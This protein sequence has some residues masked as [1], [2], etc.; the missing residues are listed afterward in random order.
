[1]TR[2]T[3]AHRI[4]IL[5]GMSVLLA[6]GGCGK[7]ECC[8]CDKLVPR[9]AIPI[10]DEAQ[11]LGKTEADYPE[12]SNPIWKYMDGDT[13]D[14][15]GKHK[16]LELTP[17]EEKGRN[18]WL[19]W[20]GG[21][22]AFWDWFADHSLGLCDLLKV[23]DSRDRG[24]RFEKYGLMSE[25]G[26]RQNLT[27]DENGLYLDVRTDP[28]E[29]SKESVYGLPSGI[30]GLRLFKNPNF[31]EN[32]K[33]A[34]KKGVDY[35]TR[36]SFYEDPRLIRPYRV[37]MACAFCH[38][39]PHPLYPPEDKEA[40][41]WENLSS[42]IGAQYFKVQPIFGTLQKPESYIFQ[43][44]ASSR[45]GTLDT[46]LIPTDNLNNPNTMNA[47]FNVGARLARASVNPP[48]LQ[49]D[50]A[51]SVVADAE[52][53]GLPP[54]SNKSRHTPHVLVDGADSI[55]ISGALNRVF[56]NIGTF[57]DYWIKT[58]NPLVGGRKQIPFQIEKARK[59]SV[60]WR[61][62]EL[63]TVNLAKFFLKEAKPM[64][65]EKAPGGAAYL[66]KDPQVLDLGKKV[67][68]DHCFKCHSSKQPETAVIYNPQFQLK[69]WMAAVST[70]EYQD[71]ARQMVMD[72][73]FLKDNFLSIDQRF[74]VDFIG[75]NACRA[76][77]TNAKKCNVWGN[78]SSELYKSS[79]AV[80][81]KVCDPTEEE[82]CQE[83]H[84]PS[85]HREVDF[86]IGGGGPGYYRVPTL[87][88]LWATAP[89]FHNN[90]LGK[91]EGDPSVEGRMKCFNDSI[92]RLLWPEDRDNQ[93][94][95]WVTDRESKLT[96]NTRFA[97]DVLTGILDRKC[98]VVLHPWL[99][100]AFVIVVGAALIWLG[101]KKLSK[102]LSFTGGVVTAI[103]V[104]GL[105]AIIAIFWSPELTIDGIPKRMPVNLLSNIDM[106][107]DPS[108]LIEAIAKT[109]EGIEASKKASNDRDALKVFLKIAG[110]AL[111]K[112]NK[113][114]D[115]VE[116]RG[117][118][119]GSQLSDEEKNA[120]IAFLKTF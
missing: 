74:P 82:Y 106:E 49:G 48:E 15:P 12:E 103:G 62:T 43:H 105:G 66:T 91:T 110:P 51:L 116:D 85:N 67:F 5:A 50:P 46:S 89:F 108:L 63:R 79:E 86:K 19:M 95:I 37:G 70:P 60:Y 102:P 104:I 31:N 55:G 114:P 100:P 81:I 56:I 54:D 98:F 71:K 76:C 8:E 97:E 117:H 30:V 69:E 119:F 38:V 77:G 7:D 29:A 120:L 3:R 36:P 17:D 84:N 59:S 26:F 96:L 101:R 109:T 32:A 93:K 58:Q 94:S 28:P 20:C 65:L 9:D 2:G 22:E 25:P 72:K 75:T 88:S 45:P 111:W 23:L 42:S 78:F 83:G 4:L 80:T 87:I 113:C 115:F 39:G 6:A 57:H 10:M 61:V 35:Y 44:L 11:M 1:M 21:N 27:P 16:V 107:A 52:K 99:V 118:L 18:T 47:I 13:P 90:A 14:V 92:H 68:A 112:V 53:L 34:W 33:I 41:R 73:D 24:H 64:P 40:P